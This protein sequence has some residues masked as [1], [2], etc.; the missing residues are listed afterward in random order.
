[1]EP[2]ADIDKDIAGLNA[3]APNW[4]NQDDRNRLMATIMCFRLPLI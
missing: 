2:G 1:M 4:S 3:L